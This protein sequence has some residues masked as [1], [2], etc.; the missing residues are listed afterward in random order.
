M[1]DTQLTNAYDRDIS[2]YSFPASNEVRFDWELPVD[3][4]N[5]KAIVEFGLLTADGTL[6]A[7]K[8]RK[9]GLPIYKESDI[10][11]EGTWTIIF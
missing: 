2:G 10:S 1:G 9:G 6:F 5:G 3:E 8:V 4:D 7:R 11:I